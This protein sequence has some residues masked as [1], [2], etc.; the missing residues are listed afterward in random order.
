MAALTPCYVQVF[1]MK[2]GHIQAGNLAQKLGEKISLPVMIAP[3][4]AHMTA[5]PEGELATARGAGMSDTLMMLSTGSNYSMEEV[6]E[7]A[8]GPLWFQLYHRGYQRTEML[9]RRAEE[10]G[11]KAV[12]LTIDTPAPSPKER[13]LRN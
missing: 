10:S 2:P 7:A 13:D 3:A 9:V 8:S 6:A 11:F 4:G 5:H 12:V 1:G